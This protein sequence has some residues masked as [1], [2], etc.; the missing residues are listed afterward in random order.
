[1]LNIILILKVMMMTCFKR[2]SRHD[3][4]GN[5]NFYVAI[6]IIKYKVYIK[7]VGKINEKNTRYIAIKILLNI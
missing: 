3:I 2:V 1:M 6:A 4:N 5:N 7:K